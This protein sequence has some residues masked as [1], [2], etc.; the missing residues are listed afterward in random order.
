VFVMVAWFAAGRLL[1]GARQLEAR[2]ELPKGFLMRVYG[3]FVGLLSTLM[4]VGGGLFAN[5]LMTSTAGRSIRR[6]R[7][8]R[9][10]RC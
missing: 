8:R 4:G 10:L 5:L 7:P 9:R 2:D 6:S 3:F 1:L